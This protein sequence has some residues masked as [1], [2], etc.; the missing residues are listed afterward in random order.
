MCYIILVMIYI[1]GLF[2]IVDIRFVDIDPNLFRQ[3]HGSSLKF[4]NIGSHTI[5]IH[6]FSFIN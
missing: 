1:L 6:E 5:V 2:G 3:N 4:S